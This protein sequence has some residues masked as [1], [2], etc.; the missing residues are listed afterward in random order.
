MEFDSP[1]ADECLVKGTLETSCVPLMQ[2]CLILLS[3]PCCMI[4]FCM[5]SQVSPANHIDT[6]LFVVCLFETRSHYVVLAILELTHIDQ[7][8]LE[9][10]ESHLSLSSPVLGIMVRAPMPN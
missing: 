2:Y 1:M 7:A 5:M 4:A 10:I 9:L 6:V 3:L 8:G